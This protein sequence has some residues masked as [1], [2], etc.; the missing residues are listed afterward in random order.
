MVPR[1]FHDPQNLIIVIVLFHVDFA[2]I[3]TNDLLQY[4]FAVDRNNANVYQFYQPEN[5]SALRMLKSF[6]DTAKSMHKPLNICGE[7][8][9]DA[10]YLPLLIG[11]GYENL[12]IDYHTIHKV[13]DYLSGLDP[14]M[15]KD[16][17]Y[18]CLTATKTTETRKMI[19]NFHSHAQ[20][21]SQSMYVD[22][23]ALDPICKMVVHTE[24]NT[25]MVR[26]QERTYYF[27][28]AVCRDMY[29][30]KKAMGFY[31]GCPYF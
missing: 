19:D 1:G 22:D 28:S 13:K 11:L 30:Q 6:V 20:D 7:I 21:T 12:S 29:L 3:G 24:G 5:P 17:A 31:D 14:T 15:C 10:R 23:E 18:K 9:S 2:S 4:F 25:L 27:C 16:L 8:A 26:D